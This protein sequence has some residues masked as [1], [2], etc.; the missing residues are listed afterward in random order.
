MISLWEGHTG[1]E[2][3]MGM[4][5]HCSTTSCSDLWIITLSMPK[6]NVSLQYWKQMH[7]STWNLGGWCAWEN[8]LM[9]CMMCRYVWCVDLHDAQNSC[10]DL[11]DVLICMIIWSDVQIWCTD[12]YDDV[13]ICMMSTSDVLICMMCWSAWWAYLMCRS[14]VQIGCADLHDEETWCEDLMCWPDVHIWCT[15]R[16]VW[17]AELL[18]C[19]CIWYALI[20]RFMYI[21]CRFVCALTCFD[22]MICVHWLMCRR[23]YADLYDYIALPMQHWRLSKQIY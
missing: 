19:M 21:M 15:D 12:L 9:C 17:C 3:L 1:R 18:I 11:Y 20:D 13:L 5:D 2:Y 4:I 8:D 22:L 14:D 7:C 10:A 6:L 23:L 16:Y